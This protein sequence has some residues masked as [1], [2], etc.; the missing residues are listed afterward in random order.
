[1]R[2]DKGFQR[3]WELIIVWTLTYCFLSFWAEGVAYLATLLSCSW[4][5]LWKTFSHSF[6][7]APKR[8]HLGLVCKEINYLATLPVAN[9]LYNYQMYKKIFSN[10][11][12]WTSSV[13]LELKFQECYIIDSKSILIW[14]KKNSSSSLGATTSQV[15]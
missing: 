13:K 10:I 12:L 3:K 4:T 5:H 7:L 2:F 9:L 15:T 6:F 11:R 1:M 14:A 8:M